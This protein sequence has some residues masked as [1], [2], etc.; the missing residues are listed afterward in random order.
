MRT[1][2]EIEFIFNGD[3]RS[4]ATLKA[5]R[6]ALIFGQGALIPY[7]PKQSR[8][9]KCSQ[10]RLYKN[11]YREPRPL[12]SSHIVSLSLSLSL[13]LYLSLSLSLDMAS[14]SVKA[15]QKWRYCQHAANAHNVS[16]K[17]WASHVQSNNQIRAFQK[18]NKKH[19]LTNF[20]LTDQFRL[21]SIFVAS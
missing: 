11:C 14:L 19:D 21:L 9:S 5:M 7:P 13:S 18:L 1:H 15:K 4:S 8:I 16:L 20:G 10:L 2:F 6:G 17:M 12:F 3:A